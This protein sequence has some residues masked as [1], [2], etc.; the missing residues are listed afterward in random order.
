MAVIDSI[1][2]LRVSVRIDDS[3]VAEYTDHYESASGQGGEHNPA[4]PFG[5]RSKVVTKYIECIDGAKFSVHISVTNQYDLKE[6]SHTLNFATY[7]D[8]HWAKGELCRFY[9]TERV[10]WETDIVGRDFEKKGRGIVTQAFQFGSVRTVDDDNASRVTDDQMKAKSMG[11]I[12][13]KAF[14]VVEH[15]ACEFTPELSGT[16]SL[17][18]AKNSLK[19]SAVSHGTTFADPS[20]YK[21][22]QCP[23]LDVPRYVKCTPL[24]G[25]TGPFAIFRFIYRTRDGLIQEGVLPR[26]LANRSMTIDD[27]PF[28]HLSD[29]QAQRLRD[30]LDRRLSGSP[31]GR[32]KREPASPAIKFDISE[33]V[34]LTDKV[35]GI[36]RQ[37]SVRAKREAVVPTIMREFGRTTDLTAPPVPSYPSKRARTGGKEIE[38]IELD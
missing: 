35:G 32:A 25:D 28:D 5:F 16:K 8:G 18:L 23:E 38:V 1:V 13:L 2:G 19:G 33:T 3:D 17:E 6:P 11:M 24:P 26:P 7:V 4:N 31:V 37:T 10:P 27:I 30:R 29:E 9:D 22:S 14:R 12:E 15:G 21:N 34:D 20:K 36:S